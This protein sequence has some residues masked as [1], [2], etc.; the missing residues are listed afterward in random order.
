MRCQPLDVVKM[1][2]REH[3]FEATAEDLDRHTDN[4]C[5]NLFYQM[6]KADAVGIGIPVTAINVSQDSVSDGGID[7]SVNLKPPHDGHLIV[8]SHP[9]YQIKAGKTFKPWLNA[10]IEKELLGAHERRAK[11]LGRQ[12][13]RCFAN[14]HTYILVCMKV[15]L[16]TRRRDDAIKN[17]KQVARGCEMPD[18][19]VRVWGQDQV[20]AVLNLF[21][22]L[23][24]QVNG[25]STSSVMSRDIWSAKDKR[26]LI[27]MEREQEEFVNELRKEL[28]RDDKPVH[29]NVFGDAGIGKT[30][31]VMEATSDPS[32]NQL[33]VYCTSPKFFSDHLLPDL[34]RANNMQAILV[35]DDCDPYQIWNET[36]NMNPGIKLVTISNGCKMV[37]D[38]TCLEVPRLSDNGIKSILFDYV[39]DNVLAHRLSVQCG[40]IPKIAHGAGLDAQQNPDGMFGGGSLSHVF[41][42][43]IRLGDEPGSARVQQRER[44]LLVLSLFKKFYFGRGFQ[45]E[46][47]FVFKLVRCLDGS[48]YRAHFNE[49]IAALKKQKM[50][51]GEDALCLTHKMLRIWLWVRF[52]ETHGH[53][54][55]VVSLIRSMPYSLRG[56]FLDMFEYVSHS[57][58]AK[59]VVK[60]PF[61]ESGPLH[62][63]DE[64][65]TEI[66]SKLFH[67][68]SRADPGFALLHLE[69]TMRR[70]DQ[71]DLQNFTTGRQAVIDGLERIMFE[72]N[73]FERGGRLLRR[74]AE[75]ENEAGHHNAT[76]AFCNMFSLDPGY[77]SNTKAPPSY[78]MPLLRE[79]LC[80][81]DAKRRGLGM[82][83]CRSA[84]R[85]KYSSVSNQAHGDLDLDIKGWQPPNVAQWQESY[86]EAMK[87]LHEKMAEFRAD[88]RR[89][90]AQI[91]MECSR[92]L[93]RTFPE[94]S[95]YVIGELAEIRDVVDDETLLRE[96]LQIIEF[97][98]DRLGTD[99]VS[100]LERLSDNIVGNSYS[101][102]MNRYVRMDPMVD[103]IGGEHE[104]TRRAKIKD[105]ANM[106]LDA[107][108]LR[109]HL[110]WLVTNDAKCGNLFGYE[111]SLLDRDESLLPEILNAQRGSGENG[112][113]SFLGGY[114]AGM[115]QI[116]RNRWSRV[117]RMISEDAGLLRFFVELARSGI[118]DEIGMVLLDLVRRSKVSA[119][120]LS[121]LAFGLADRPSSKVTVQW[122]NAM[123]LSN[124]QEAVAGALKLYYSFFV[125]RRKEAI[126]VDLALCILTH[127]TLL[128]KGDSAPDGST[129]YWIYWK[130]IAI[131]LIEQ[132]PEKSIQLGRKILESVD[133]IEMMMY[134]NHMMNVIDKIAVGFPDEMWD[135]VAQYINPPLDKRG[136]AISKWMRSG[137]LGADGRF[138]ALVKNEKIF[139]W[140]DYSPPDRAPLMARCVPPQ[141]QGDNCIAIELLKRY[142]Q[143][144]TVQEALLANFLTG[145]A[146]YSE[147]QDNKDAKN[148]ALRCKESEDDMLVN[149][150]LD[151][152]VAIL[153]K[154]IGPNSS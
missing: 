62:S 16:D 110:D 48:V 39:D 50:L 75:A 2:D 114:M 33:V 106:S 7:A 17:L 8:G 18:P 72:P 9:S 115:F 79:T 122:I 99:A 43:Y 25:R 118:T 146:S 149:G 29:V 82:K 28:S 86:L 65:K 101:E 150:W 132:N 11:G 95:D 1:I 120:Q 138:L 111:L 94:I 141:L 137:V 32:L 56:W 133:G 87:L 123:V 23:A 83:A 77:M 97:D 21:P 41:E 58:E 142:G 70:W 64:L 144:D 96:I 71:E 127:D 24:L 19:D 92:N 153:E 102:L 131:R 20:L 54:F 152:Y 91:I 60:R 37:P 128:S 67:A 89:A 140:I 134:R 119:S 103:P 45:E 98:S 40:G 90:G 3:Y 44:V 13:R 42:R 108:I 5:M 61:D 130:K 84:L 52:W 22:S 125:R 74:L 121:A 147:L 113:G 35:I 53:D 93:L 80:G 136:R 68:A 46:D 112:S 73:L 59:V 36:K 12:T 27:V 109:P 30:L 143:D 69:E 124:R 49:I 107:T 66:G 135:M 139:D 47:D 34:R 57:N 126:D 148:A 15:K 38:I 85:I 51:Y 6:L 105:L 145:T 129:V 117:M 116:D 14:Q 100:G 4:E 55:D 63:P 104:G 154:R 88:E 10:V 26:K 151:N 31:L 76:R 78:R 81:Q